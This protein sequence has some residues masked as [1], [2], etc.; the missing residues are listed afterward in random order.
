MTEHHHA[1]QH[2]H[3]QGHGHALIDEADWRAWAEHTELQ[4]EVFL[5][6]VT[7]AAA[8]VDH[9]RPAD[10]PVVRRILD[11]G[12]GPGVASCELARWYPHAQVVAVDSSPAMLERAKRRADAQGLASRVSTHL[13]E[14]PG[15]LDD[16]EPVDLIWA[17]MSLHHVGDEV[18]AL[19][20]LRDLLHPQGV[21]IVVELGGPTRFL[22]DGFDL[23]DAGLIERIDEA[24]R[25]W[26]AQMR[27]GLPDSS[28]SSDFPAMLAAAGFHDVDTRLDNQRFDAPL[29]QAARQVL[30]GDVERLRH[31]LDGFLDKADLAVLDTLL[32]DHDSRGVMHRDDLFYDSSRLVMFGRPMSSANPLPPTTM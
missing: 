25:R 5:A 14:L 22:P 18:A 28:A 17:S 1:H 10:A 24:S 11:I 6:F 15:G 31:Q 29:S 8:R 19:R 26:F 4:G 20:V 7:N 13:A 12:S 27:A 21:I 2:Q 23:G 3:G 32:D 16:I 9:L 30:S